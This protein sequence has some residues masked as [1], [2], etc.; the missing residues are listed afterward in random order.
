MIGGEKRLRDKKHLLLILYVPVYL[1][2]FFLVELLV[3]STGDYWVSYCFL[4]DLIPFNEYFIIP[5]YLWYPY[6]FAVGIYLMARDVPEFRRYMYCIIMGFSF[7]VV[8]CLVFPNGQDLRPETFARDNVFVSLVKAI[9]AVDTNTNVIPSV[10]A[11][12]AIFGAIGIC[13]TQ[14]LK[15]KWIKA[16]VVLLAVLISISTCFVKQHS[17]LDVFAAM[18][19]CVVIYAIVYIFIK[20]KLMN[21]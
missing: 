17:I 20:K 5:Y 6:L 11:V 3:P 12:G 21:S 8:F 10:H 2:S 4:D 18:A 13:S 16:T 19:L 1:I 9:Y 14:T 7:C 15:R